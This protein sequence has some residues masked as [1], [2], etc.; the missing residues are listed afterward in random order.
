MTGTIAEY[1]AWRAARHAYAGP[2]GFQVAPDSLHPSLRPDQRAVVAWALEQGRAALFVNTGGG[3]TFDQLEWA[4]VISQKAAGKV[5]ILAPLVVAD[6]TVREANERWG[7]PVRYVR[8]QADA[9]A[10]PERIVVSNYEVMHHFN[11][12]HFTGIVGDESSFLKNSRG[13]YRHTFN[14][15]WAKTRYK[16]LCTATPAPNEYDE[17]G[18]HSQALGI[19]P[20]HEMVTRWFIRDSAHA[21][22]LRLKGHAEADFWRWLASWSVCMSKPSDIG[23]SDDGFQLPPLNIHSEQVEV[24]HH[25][26]WDEGRL[27]YTEA[28]SAT[29]LWRNKRL[30]LKGRMERAAGIVAQDPGAPWV[31][32]VETNDEAD[33][34]R[35]MLPGAIEVRGSESFEEKRAKLHAFTV[36]DERVLITKLDIAGFGMNW[37]HCSNVVFASLTYSFERTYQGIRRFWRYGQ[38]NPVNIWLI[39]SSTESDVLQAV[40]RKEAQFAVMQE[41]MNSA[42]HEVG[43]TGRRAFSDYDYTPAAPM[44]IPSFVQSKLGAYVQ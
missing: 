16:L 18:N 42:M 44:A 11:A 30:T 20:W 14:R 13:V 1:R 37:Q 41:K 3:K 28:L 4:R 26:A 34:I 17:L 9:D 40:R 36:G 2:A 35:D 25:S 15:Q 29:E 27:F 32:W 10:A 31:V 33:A 39:T 23:F 22:T 21:D 38:Q 7:I 5:L 8:N 6:Q 24:D 19:M 43:L 12:D